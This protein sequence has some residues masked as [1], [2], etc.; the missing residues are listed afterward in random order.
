M[1][2]KPTNADRAQWA[3]E[4]LA[5]FTSRTFGGGHPDTMDRDD[6][7]F[8]LSDLIADLLHYARQ[9]DYDIGSVVY[10]A[11]G[12]FGAEILDE[13]SATPPQ[14]ASETESALLKALNYLLEQTVD[15]DL[16]YGITL[17]EGEADARQQALAA[18]ARSAHGGRRRSMPPSPSTSNR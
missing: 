7:Q 2:D 18:I 5:A 16:K 13:S 10:R 9:Q 6:R 3:K 15:H 8:A 12:H 11:C 17:S 4:A 1:S 14:D